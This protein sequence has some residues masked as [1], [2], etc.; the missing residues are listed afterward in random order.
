MGISSFADRLDFDGGDKRLVAVEVAV[1]FGEGA[2][3][4]EFILTQI[5]GNATE[6]PPQND[7]V[8][9]GEGK[10]QF[11][12]RRVLGV[13]GFGVGFKGVFNQ[14]AGVE[15]APP[16]LKME[17]DAEAIHVGS[18]VTIIFKEVHGHRFWL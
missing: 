14:L 15:T 16:P 1:A 2:D 8:G 6:P 12:R 17:L 5:I 11:V 18:V 9:G 7:H 4:G 10:S 13:G 3:G